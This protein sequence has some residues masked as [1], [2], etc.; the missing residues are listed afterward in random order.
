MVGKVD[1]VDSDGAIVST[2]EA[3]AEIPLSSV[4]KSDK[5]L[6]ITVTKGEIDAQTKKT[7]TKMK[8]KN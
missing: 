5:G 7:N 6:V 8:P 4:G 1:S 2:G 3:R